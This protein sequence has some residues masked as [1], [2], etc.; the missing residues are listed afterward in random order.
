[1]VKAFN[2]QQVPVLID[3]D[4]IAGTAPAVYQSFPGFLRVSVIAVKQAAIPDQEFSL[5]S[6]SD[7]STDGWSS[8]AL[9]FDFPFTV[10]GDK[11]SFGAAIIL[12]Q[13]NTDGM[14]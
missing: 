5:I 4:G 12:P 1:M 8:H 14:D 3:I 6:Y 9:K 7:F 2:E 11:S 10:G 13:L